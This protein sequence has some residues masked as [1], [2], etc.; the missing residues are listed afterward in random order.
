MYGLMISLFVNHP[1]RACPT[2]G[3]DCGSRCSKNLT[4]FVRV[5]VLLFCFS[6]NA[7]CELVGEWDK[8]EFVKMTITVAKQKRTT[9]FSDVG[10]L[11]FED[12]IINNK[13]T[14]SYENGLGVFEGTFKQ[15]IQ[16]KNRIDA[17]KFSFTGTINK[18]L[19]SPAFNEAF[20]FSDQE[21]NTSGYR[22]TSATFQGEEING[23]SNQKI[24][25]GN[26]LIKVKFM[27]TV[28]GF[29]KK[30]PGTLII[31]SF[32]VANRPQ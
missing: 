16:T 15:K 17:P 25:F 8:T 19:L 23:E 12:Q 21:V 18:D 27:M 3:S 31:D 5:C 11:L 29:S 9:A 10:S 13:G 1:D 14:I 32:F 4:L 26:I 30:I 20:S 22:V 7:H 24:L 28:T 2:T 6:Q